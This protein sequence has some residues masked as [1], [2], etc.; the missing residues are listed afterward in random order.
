MEN[1]GDDAVIIARYVDV[2]QAE[3]AVSVLAGRGI[4]A[5]IDVPYTANIFPHYVAG[6]GGVAVSVRAEDAGEATK[7]LENEGSPTE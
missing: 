7:V 3:F 4:D 2:R 6:S 1:P 5:F